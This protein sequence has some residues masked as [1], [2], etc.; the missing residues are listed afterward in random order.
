MRCIF[1]TGLIEQRGG[2]PLLSVLPDVLEWPIATDDWDTK[3][4]TRDV[5][6]LQKMCVSSCPVSHYRGFLNILP[7]SSG[8]QWRAE[9]I[10]AKLNEKYAK[11]V[12]IN[13]FVSTDDRD[14]NAHIIHVGIQWM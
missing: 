3:Y 5:L 8:T 2:S 4:G 10:L 13:F 1:L 9:D 14:S 11:P 7:S 6:L 12:L